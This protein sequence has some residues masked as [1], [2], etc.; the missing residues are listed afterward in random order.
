MRYILMIAILYVLSSCDSTVSFKEALPPGIDE[1][2]HIPSNFIGIFMC[3][4]DSTKVH[5]TTTSIYSER[6]VGM[7]LSKNKTYENEGCNITDGG[8]FIRGRQECIPILAESKDSVYI[9]LVDRDTFFAFREGEVLKS[10]KGHLF[11]NQ[12]TED[13]SWVTFI[14]SPLDRSTLQF[15]YISIPN[16]VAQVRAITEDFIQ[17]DKPEENEPYFILN[18]DL[19]EFQDL[20]NQEFRLECETLER[21]NFEYEMFIPKMFRYPY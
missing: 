12:R 10:Y 9:E 14:L 8:V 17:L 7:F 4:S 1:I 6:Y 20:L 18:P 15:D 16:E 11:L 13:A 5:I 2:E 3:Q 19:I 21:I